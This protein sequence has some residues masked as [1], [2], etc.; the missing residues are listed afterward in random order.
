MKKLTVIVLAILTMSMFAFPLTMAE[1]GGKSKNFMELKFEDEYKAEAEAKFAEFKEKDDS[2]LPMFPSK[3]YSFYGKTEDGTEF[4]GYLIIRRAVDKVEGGEISSAKTEF[5]GE[6]TFD[7]EIGSYK[8]LNG[9]LDDDSVTADLLRYTGVDNEKR[10]PTSSVTI[11][12]KDKN[13]K[14]HNFPEG[15]SEELDFEI[16]SIEEQVIADRKPSEPFV[17]TPEQGELKPYRPSFFDRVFKKV[18]VV[19]KSAYWA[20]YD[21]T[22]TT[23]YSEEYLTSEDWQEKAKEFC[24]D[25]PGK[26]KTGVN[27]FKLIDPVYREVDSGDILGNFAQAREEFKDSKAELREK[28]ADVKASGEF[29]EKKEEL[30]E[31]RKNILVEWLKE[32]FLRS[33]SNN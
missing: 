31:E 3:G 24:E 28:V 25:Y 11:D 23:E 33:E 30:K 22:E 6:I 2:D 12:L 26:E 29:Q 21:G 13:G 27:T 7:S 14:F 19:S 18:E 15:N 1:R 20:C 17:A 8:I 5:S 9:A 16:L 32:V 4:K 10:L